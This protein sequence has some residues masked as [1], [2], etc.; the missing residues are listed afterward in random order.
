MPLGYVALQVKPILNS[1]KFMEYFVWHSLPQT[2]DNEPKLPVVKECSTALR[3][4]AYRSRTLVVPARECASV[5]R[6]K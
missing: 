1:P 2:S 6:I 4:R 5:D 3:E